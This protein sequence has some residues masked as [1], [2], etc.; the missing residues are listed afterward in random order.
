MA[1]FCSSAGGN[2]LLVRVRRIGQDWLEHVTTLTV[3]RY[4]WG[5]CES[6]ITQIVL[7]FDEDSP[8]CLY[9]DKARPSSQHDVKKIKKQQHGAGRFWPGKVWWQCCQCCMLKYDV[10]YI[11]IRLFSCDQSIHKL[12]QNFLICSFGFV[13]FL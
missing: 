11:S 6:K 4:L 7:S 13:L 3:G 2:T 1:I 8:S 12:I 5:K 10:L 9:L